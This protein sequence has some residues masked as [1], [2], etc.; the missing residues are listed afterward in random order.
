MSRN[1]RLDICAYKIYADK[2][3]PQNISLNIYARGNMW[4]SYQSPHCIIVNSY[5]NRK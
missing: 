5:L 4:G 2:Y 3:G 1:E